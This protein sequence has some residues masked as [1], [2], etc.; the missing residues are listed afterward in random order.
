VI[1]KKAPS[2]DLWVGQTDEGELGFSYEKADRVLFA[3]VEQ[4]M[5]SDDCVQ[6]GFEESFIHLLISR[7]LRYQYKRTHPPV[8]SI[9][10]QD[11]SGIEDLPAFSSAG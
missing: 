6:A 3:L 8:G 9:G 10:Q 1:I 11:L 2:A 4:K 7:V 5:D